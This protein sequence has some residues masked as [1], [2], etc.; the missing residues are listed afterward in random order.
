MTP[1]E[2]EQKV[3]VGMI[4][5][6]HGVR[7]V[8]KVKSFTTC[9][10]DF[11][12]YGD[13]QDVTGKRTF[14]VEIVGENKDQFLV[15]IDGINDRNKAEELRGV[16]LYVDR[17][18]LPETAEDEFY[19]TDLIGM[20]A[21]SPEGEIIGS[22]VA[23][24]NFGAGDMLEI[25]KQDSSLELVSFSD[26]TVPTVNVKERELMVKMPE[27]VDVKPM[28]KQSVSEKNNR[29]RTQKSRAVDNG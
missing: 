9:A 8:V 26:N 20:T 13:L 12:A 28:K 17:G 25:K 19:Y 29:K 2:K 4:T 1:M 3:C 15:Q 7:G 18:L 11:A 10:E 16:K 24:Y 22:V 27:T 6:A 14:Q 23:V 5:T 21:K